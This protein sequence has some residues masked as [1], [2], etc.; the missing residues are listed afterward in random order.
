MSESSFGVRSSTVSPP[1]S[2][3]P[4]SAPR[5]LTMTRPCAFLTARVPSPLSSGRAAVAD[6]TAGAAI[7]RMTKR[8]TSFRI[9]TRSID[10]LGVPSMRETL[11]KCN[12]GGGAPAAEFPA[13]VARVGEVAGFG[14]IVLV[15][16]LGFSVALGASKLA[17]KVPIPAPA[18][19]LVAAAI[20]SDLFPQLHDHLTI[21]DVERIAV[22]ALIV[23]LFGGGYEIGLHRFRA[24]V[25]PIA[26]LG[27]VGTFATAGVI[28]TFAHVA[29]GL[30]WTTAGLLGAALAPTAP[31]VMFSVL[32]GREI[33]GRTGTILQGESGA[34]DPVG[35][36]L[37]I[38][39]I[40]IAT[41][42]DASFLAVGREFV[43]EMAVGL[44][45]GIAGGLLETWLLR[46]L[47]LPNL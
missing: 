13:T 43:V 36:A 17:D 6:A 35:I 18:F 39:M 30:G 44:A 1:S 11:G 34:N 3:R 45:I 46:N 8:T 24:S 40:D 23:I 28:A 16:A 10:S 14:T 32:G 19:F 27:V 2:S 4:S 15:V 5:A 12:P 31:A 42:S 38:G 9:C 22:V 33:A 37:M 26:S 41:K 47:S 7:A 29:F 25:V 20:A 21:R